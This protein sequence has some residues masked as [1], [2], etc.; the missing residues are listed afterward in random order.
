MVTLV[1]QEQVETTNLVRHIVSIVFP[2]QE[3]KR[4]PVE[5]KDLDEMDFDPAVWRGSLDPRDGLP[6]DHP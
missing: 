3:S 5:H 6:P 2:P 1:D 4:N